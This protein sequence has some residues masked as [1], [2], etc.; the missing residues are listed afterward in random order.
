M[1]WDVLS[2]LP[3]LGDDV[4]GLQVLSTTVDDV[5][6]EGLAPLADSLD[7]L[8]EVSSDGRVDVDVVRSM[9]DPVASANEVIGAASREVNG[10]DSDGFIGPLR[11]RYERYADILDDAA[12][13]LASADTAVRVLPDMVGADGPRDYLLLFQNNAE[14]RATGGM[15]GSWAQ[16]HA[17]D[18]QLEMTQQGTATDFPHTDEPVLPLTDEEVEIYGEEIG[19][20]FQDPGFAPDFPRA[21]ELW[22]AHWDGKFPDTPIDGVLALDPVGM[23]YLLGGT[24]PVAGRGRHPH[25]G[26]PGRGA[27]QPAVPGAGRRRPRTQLFQDAARAIFDAVT[28]DLASPVDFVD[29]LS[30]ATRE[31]RFL[32]GPFDEEDAEILAGSTS[33]ASSAPTR[34]K[35]P[36]VDIGLNDATG[37][38]MSYYLRS[39]AEIESSSCMDDRQQLDAALKLGQ[40]ITP[41]AAAKLPESVTGGGN[42]GTEPGSQLVVVRLYGPVGGTIENVVIDGHRIDIER[43]CHRGR[44]PSGDDPRRHPGDPRPGGADLVDGDRP[45]PDR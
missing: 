9:Q 20:Y 23:S 31:G 4:E 42:H 30:R 2:K 12:S 1:W 45:G 36:Y 44:R 25:R 21:A 15:P 5:A 11:T 33:S 6:N 37:S 41:E 7:R 27:A 17:E 34:P 40:V 38:K 35:T 22:R 8:D 16:I 13:S 26:Q 39:Q 10:L 24:G 3:V 19:T 32:V 18:G 28:G 14:I 43:R 29:G